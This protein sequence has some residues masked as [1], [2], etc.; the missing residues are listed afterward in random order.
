MARKNICNCPNPPGGQVV[1][2]ENQMAIC[3]VQNGQSTYQCLSPISDIS[4]IVQI[5]W[6]L[7][8]ITGYARNYYSK[9]ENKDLIMLIDG[10]YRRQNEMVSFHLP[11]YIEIAVY[12]ILTDRT[13]GGAQGGTPVEVLI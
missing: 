4:P 9:I 8:Q 7:T 10:F 12:K 6:A 2:E 1:C 11:E 5:N 3:I 13:K